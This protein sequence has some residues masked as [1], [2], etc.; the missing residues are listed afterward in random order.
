MESSPGPGVWRRPGLALTAAP[1][2]TMSVASESGGSS[3]CIPS[4]QDFM[5]G[6][7]VLGS[8]PSSEPQPL[9]PWSG[10]E[11]LC[12]AWHRAVRWQL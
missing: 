12:S 8:A 4:L 9:W 1:L 3:F 7:R 2:G 11:S 10:P 5:R 6:Q